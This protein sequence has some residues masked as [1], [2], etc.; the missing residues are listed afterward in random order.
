MAAVAERIGG[1]GG[2]H[3]GAAGWSGKADRI[4]AESAFIAQVAVAKREEE[5]A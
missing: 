5:Q 3:D 2:G 4:A 1:E